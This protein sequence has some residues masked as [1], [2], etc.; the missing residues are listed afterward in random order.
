MT[1]TRVIASL[2]G[3]LVAGCAMVAPA[4]DSADLSILTYPVG[5]VT[6]V[7]EVDVDLGVGGEPAALYLDG[8]L[9]C[10]MSESMTRCTVDF[11]AAPHVHLLELV[12]TNSSGEIT[13]HASRWVNRPGQEA[14]L[15]IP[16]APRK[17]NGI[18]SGKALWSHPSKKSPVLLEV[19]ENGRILRIREDGRSFAFPCP[20]ANEPHVLAGSAIF[21]DG[22]RAEAVALSGGFGG[23]TEAGL[24]AVALTA[25]SASENSCRVVAAGLG[26]SLIHI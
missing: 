4:S 2:T 11:G 1:K 26:L 14:E 23:V 18:C 6:G 17:A 9:V 21:A 19:T 5:L 13:G 12:R 22:K 15:V 25:D 7:H 8:E 20:D 3:G 10:S 16:L 24:S